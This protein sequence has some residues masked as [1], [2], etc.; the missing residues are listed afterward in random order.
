MF[1]HPTRPIRLVKTMPPIAV[2]RSPALIVC[3]VS[4]SCPEPASAKVGELV[5]VGANSVVGV[6]DG[7]GVGISVAVAVLVGKVV[8]VGLVVEV[9]V[10]VGVL[11]GVC[12]AEGTLTIWG[13]W[14]LAAP[15]LAEISTRPDSGKEIVVSTRPLRVCSIGTLT[16]GPF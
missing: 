7:G 8:I 3:P 15:L 2:N 10:E 4:S 6:A 5:G 13:R 12:G 11:V 14:L 16:E 1:C 9:G